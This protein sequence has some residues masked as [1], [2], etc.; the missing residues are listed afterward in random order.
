MASPV[1]AVLPCNFDQQPKQGSSIIRP[2]IINIYSGGKV[3]EKSVEIS[4]SKHIEDNSEAWLGVSSGVDNLETAFTCLAPALQEDT[5]Q[6]RIKTN[7][8]GLESPEIDCSVNCK[9]ESTGRDDTS[10]DI[11]A[12]EGIKGCLEDCTDS[13][14]QQKDREESCLKA[15]VGCAGPQID[16]LNTDRK[17]AGT[18]SE[19]GMT[20][21]TVDPLISK[22]TAAVIG[23]TREA[24]KDDDKS[25]YQTTQERDKQPVPPNLMFERRKQNSIKHIEWGNIIPDFP[26]RPSNELLKA[27]V[28]HE[29]R[30]ETSV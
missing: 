24:L 14:M 4:P 20:A 22:G 19:E 3:D 27:A 17:L 26:A 30:K 7:V 9:R 2:E 16:T 5:Q 15:N 29:K 13:E 1:S 28:M 12:A 10:I 21:H 6:K 8:D 25:D 23:D 18:S 11:L